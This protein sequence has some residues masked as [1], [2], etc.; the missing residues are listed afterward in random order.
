MLLPKSAALA[1]QATEWT[2]IPSEPTNTLALAGTRIQRRTRKARDLRAY[3]IE[4][5][6]DRLMTFEEFRQEAVRNRIRRE[7]GLT[8]IFLPASRSKAAP[9]QKQGKA[10]RPL[11]A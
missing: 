7:L 6:C 9:V 8:P 2:G 4:S 11:A 10:A 3:W 1:G 5:R